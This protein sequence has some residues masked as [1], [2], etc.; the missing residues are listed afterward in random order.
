MPW[1]LVNSC[2]ILNICQL[3]FSMIYWYV[4][5]D[6][7]KK[8]SI[9]VVSSFLFYFYFFVGLQYL[10]KHPG[11]IGVFMVLIW[12]KTSIRCIPLLTLEFS[13]GTGKCLV[14]SLCPLHILQTLCKFGLLH[15]FSISVSVSICC[16]VKPLWRQLAYAQIYEYNRIS[17][18]LT[19]LY[20]FCNEYLFFSV[21]LGS[22]YSVI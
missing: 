9:S 14:L 8:A 19:S 20:F 7:S 13:F 17:L 10:Y 3:K 11:F 5:G 4:G 6:L 15:W 2:E 21:S 1:I 18:G 12:K 22:P 16:W